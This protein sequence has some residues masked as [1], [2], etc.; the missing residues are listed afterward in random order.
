MAEINAIP[1]IREKQRLVLFDALLGVYNG[2]P[3]WPRRYIWP[4]GGILVGTD[5]VA[6]DAV[7]LLILDEK[8]RAE[9]MGSLI[10]RAGSVN[11]AAALGLGT[12]DRDQIDLIEV[13]LG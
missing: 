2:G 12:A 13:T 4:Y 1:V 7:A 10:G 8:R 3:R 11:A 6:M 9:G 5:P